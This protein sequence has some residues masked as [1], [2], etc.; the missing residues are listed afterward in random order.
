MKIC[1]LNL[2]QQ[3]AIHMVK[4]GKNL[5]I[6]GSGGTGKTAIIEVL[7]KECSDKNISIIA[8]TGVAARNAK[9]ETIHSFFGFGKG[10][11]INDKTLSL[12]EHAPKPVI[13]TDVLVI[14]EISMVGVSLFDAIMVSLEKANKVRRSEGKDDIQ[15]IALGDFFQLPPVFKFEDQLL[16]EKCYGES[17]EKGFAFQSENWDKM[18][19]F[20]IILEE[21]MRQ[22]NASLV[23]NLQLLRKYDDRCIEYFNQR[24]TGVADDE[25]VTLM[26]TNTMV[27]QYN[28]KILDS[29]EGESY[30]YLPMFSDVVD[31]TFYEIPQSVTLKVGAKVMFTARDDGKTSDLF[32]QE[33][34]KYKRPYYINGTLGNILALDK[35]SAIVKIDD[36]PVVQVGFQQFDTPKHIV[37]NNKVSITHTNDRY[38]ALPLIPAYALTI[39]KS[40]GLTLDK[41]N[42][43]PDCFAP[44]QLYVA[45]SR[46]KSFEGINLLEPITKEVIIEDEDILEFEKYI[47]GEK[48]TCDIHKLHFLTKQE[49]KKSE[50]EKKVVEEVSKEKLKE[51]RRNFFQESWKKK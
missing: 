17:V 4:E 7:K 25:A 35:D 51:I 13:K 19:F 20:P 28:K 39:H 43:T 30:T 22:D 14:D 2:K 47:R 45:L 18:H 12:K 24:Y 37:R 6:T 46:C 8:P 23:D 9:G 50:D 36:G 21:C 44:G 15:V 1:D 32:M 42:I 33:K 5:F 16:L 48:E 40:Q 29:L 34:K 49:R 31:E 3:Q 26:A 11:G 41:V 10:N 27:E 38:W